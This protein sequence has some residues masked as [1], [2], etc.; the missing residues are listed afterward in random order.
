MGWSESSL[1]SLAAL[2]KSLTTAT[3]DPH[4]DSPHDGNSRAASPFLSLPAELRIA[5]YDAYHPSSI[6]AA[7]S[8]IGIM[9]DVTKTQGFLPSFSA[10]N[11]SL[12]AI[13]KLCHINRQIR[14]EV[15][16][17]FF[18]SKT[19]AVKPDNLPRLIKVLPHQ[20]R[21][22]LSSIFLVAFPIYS[23]PDDPNHF[24]T[25][26]ETYYNADP[27]HCF[28]YQLKT[29][30]PALK[31]LRVRLHHRACLRCDWVW[32]W[33]GVEPDMGKLLAGQGPAWLSKQYGVEEFALDKNGV[34]CKFC[35]EG[36]DT[37]AQL[38]KLEGRIQERI[39]GCPPPRVDIW[40]LAGRW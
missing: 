22:I 26:W 32:G 5:I 21:N 27:R 28:R 39:A 37:A 40:R 3:L 20:A 33:H 13:F 17:H 19:V 36:G 24:H 12:G 1:T 35:R 30:F 11:D 34:Y 4:E 23:R 10:G 31:R 2:I 15:L 6:I 16:H 7:R 9:T 38:E 14:N 8:I 18:A 25:R 29:E